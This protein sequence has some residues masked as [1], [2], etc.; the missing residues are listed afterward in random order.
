MST[1]DNLLERVMQATAGLKASERRVPQA[2]VSLQN[3]API[4]HF[5]V[6]LKF[7]IHMDKELGI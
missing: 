4:V 5:H 3:A 1:K 7:K 6:L 2:A